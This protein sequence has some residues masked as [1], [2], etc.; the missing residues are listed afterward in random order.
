MPLVT[1]A[2]LGA[3]LGKNMNVIRFRVHFLAL[4]VA[5]TISWLLRVLYLPARISEFDFLHFGLM[6]FLYSTVFV[7]SLRGIGKIHV[8]PAL[9]FI[10]LATVLGALTP[11]LALWSSFVWAAPLSLILS[12]GIPSFGLLFAWGSAI[13]A[14]GY[15][16]L[17]RIFWLKSLRRRD[18]IRTVGL[19]VVATTGSILALDLISPRSGD[20]DSTWLILTTAWWFAFSASLYWSRFHG[21]TDPSACA[22]LGSI[23]VVP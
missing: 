18:C 1:L 21:P 12:S 8:L 3:K 19:C 16:L 2:K 7:I 5:A 14:L 10:T 15:W 20:A 23:T 13:G 22:P 17:V 11:I 9:L 6:G 4:I